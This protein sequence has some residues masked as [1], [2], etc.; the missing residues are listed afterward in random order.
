MLDL[1]LNEN[2]PFV[3]GIELEYLFPN[4][5]VHTLDDDDDD[6]ARDQLEA[7]TNALKKVHLTS[8]EYISKKKARGRTP[9]HAWKIVRN[10][11]GFELVSPPLTALQS[12]E[13]DLSAMKKRGVGTYIIK[14]QVRNVYKN[15]M[16][17]EEALDM[18]RDCP[19]RADNSFKSLGI[20]QQLNT[21]QE[22]YSV[23]DSCHDYFY[24]LVEKAESVSEKHD[25]G[26]WY[27]LVNLR[28]DW[29]E[30]DNED[31]SNETKYSIWPKRIEFRGQQAST[32][33][34]FVSSWVHLIH[35]MVKSSFDGIVLEPK[36]RTVEE[37]WNVL[38]D[39]LIRN[40]SLGA[41]CEKRRRSL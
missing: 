34:V 17:V 8:I 19:Q 1:G 14:N 25:G 37:A 2:L 10:R 6:V 24:C 26:D 40:N 36:E 5:T 22:G 11:A 16:A 21:L 4:T 15:F 39:K 12:I 41:N 35:N 13:A 23:L 33:G 18:L 9:A 31:G 29:E 30:L 3:F 28:Y 7:V 27:H 32:D 38:F 20:W